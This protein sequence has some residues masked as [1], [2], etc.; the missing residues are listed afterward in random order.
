M[1]LKA[2]SGSG[3]NQGC[4][5]VL[6]ATGRSHFTADLTAAVTEMKG[7]ETRDR[8]VAVM[9]LLMLQQ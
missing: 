2:L 3:S 4:L 9:P 5:D 8:H 1:D 7:Y 6:S